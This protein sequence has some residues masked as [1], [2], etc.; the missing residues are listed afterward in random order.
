MEGFQSAEMEDLT[1]KAELLKILAHPVRLCIVKGLA[2]KRECNVSFIQHCL[3]M[4]QSTI[5]QH[6]AKLRSGGIIKGKRVGV[7][8]YYKLVNPF[9]ERLIN[10]LFTKDGE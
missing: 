2:G 1:L 3:N 10:A 6:L 7:E 8:V 9:A 5:S 4:P